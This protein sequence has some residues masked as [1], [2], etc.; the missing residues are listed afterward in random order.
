[1]S[2]I[3][4]ATN[5]DHEAI[6]Q[7]HLSA[8]P[9]NERH[10]I[11]TLAVKLLD[12]ATTPDTISLVAKVDNEI[13]GHIAFSPVTFGTQKDWT[14]YILA[15]LGV[16]PEFQKH[17]IGSELIES[18]KKSLS[19]RGVNVLFVY[20]D[21]AYY[22]KFGFKTETAS[23]YLPPYE[24]AYPFGWQAAVLN[25]NYSSEVRLSVSCVASLCDPELW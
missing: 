5:L 12:E 20:G 16:K 2:R 11:A 19:E 15:P 1:M 18:G 21:P 17:R 10:V 22:S 23:S 7:V 13:V 25:G 4:A 24:L 6:R 8:F 3:Y 9:E 14:G